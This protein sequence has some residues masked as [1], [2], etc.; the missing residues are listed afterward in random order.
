MIYSS[1]QYWT[2]SKHPGW[3]S[4]YLSGLNPKGGTYIVRNSKALKCYISVDPA[5]GSITEL[6]QE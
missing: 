1:K 2:L 3:E 4:T 5:G 6:G